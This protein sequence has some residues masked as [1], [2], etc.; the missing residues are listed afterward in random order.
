M[1]DKIKSI[2]EQK[3]DFAIENGFEGQFSHSN[4][5]NFFAERELTFVPA[6]EETEPAEDKNLEENKSDENLD[7]NEPDPAPVVKKNK[8]DTLTF[9]KLGHGTHFYSYTNKEGRIEKK[10]VKKGEQV[11]VP[12]KLAA[13]YADKSSWI[14]IG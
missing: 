9:Q 13:Q 8:K 2:Y 6:M 12:A 4:L 5:D 10:M 11:I 14:K 3:K 1:S 7:E